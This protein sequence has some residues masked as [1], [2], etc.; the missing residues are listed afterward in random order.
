M[1]LL[2]IARLDMGASDESSRL[3]RWSGGAS[4]G[5]KS[6]RNAVNDGL[7]IDSAGCR[8]D[9]VGSAIIAGKIRCETCAIERAHCGGRAKDGSPDRLLGE[10]DLLQLVPNEIVGC[11]FSS[12]NLL[13]DDV[14]L[15]PQLLGIE[16]G[17]GQNVGQN[18]E[19]ERHVR[20]KHTCV[21]GRGL[22]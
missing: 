1:G 19:R 12:S 7:M 15:A 8:D 21:I 17:I 18:I 16:G 20:T 9:H 10:R 5:C 22:D 11:I 13:N 2:E 3:R 6:S 14:L 4:K